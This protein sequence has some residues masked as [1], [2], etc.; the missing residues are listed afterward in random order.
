[1]TD[2]RFEICL[3]FT[4]AQEGGRSNDA[5]D[6]GGRTDDGII[7][8]EYDLYRRSKSMPLQSVFDISVGEYTEIYFDSYWLPHCPALPAG[9]DMQFFDLAV[10]G[11][12]FEATKILQR[13]LI[14]ANLLAP[15]T[16]DGF[17][18]P[19]TSEAINSVP[20]VSVIIKMFGLCRE[21]FYRSLST[22]QYFGGDWIRRTYEI[23]AH[24]LAMVA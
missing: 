14:S 1:M 24:S 2:A 8:R 9:L 23:T 16:A 13:A 12:P 6:P 22:F 21:K 7:Q 5:H 19:K 10:N 4:L 3:P 11:G 20:D 17:F 18:G 15:N